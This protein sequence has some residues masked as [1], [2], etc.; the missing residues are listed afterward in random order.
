M[1]T[2][3]SQDKRPVGRPRRDG[4]PV[5]S[6]PNVSSGRPRGRPRKDGLPV[7]SVKFPSVAA[8]WAATPLFRPVAL[9]S[10]V[11]VVPLVVPLDYHFWAP[12]ALPPALLMF[13]NNKPG[14][15]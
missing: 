4:K 13:S 7:G 5:G 2:T 1:A 3:H 10:A 15:Q 14:G 9:F 6:I 12:V 8:P 11:P